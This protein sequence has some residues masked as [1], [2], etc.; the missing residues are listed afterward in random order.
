MVCFAHPQ[1]KTRVQIE[2]LSLAPPVALWLVPEKASLCLPMLSRQQASA[3]D[4]SQA[5]QDDLEDCC[6][7]L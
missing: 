6:V 2:V 3:A 1:L 7:E 5:K 4:W